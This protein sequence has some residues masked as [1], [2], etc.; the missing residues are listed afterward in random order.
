MGREIYPAMS[1]GTRA[2]R[3]LDVLSNNLANVGTTGFKADRATFALHS[4][5][6]A[7]DL[8]PDSA[9]ARLAAAWNALDGEATDFS[10][11]SLQPSSSPT[12]LALSGEGFFSVQGSD[13]VVRLTRDGS[14]GIG[15]DGYLA[16]RQGDRVLDQAGRPIRVEGGDFLVDRNGDVR[17]GGQVVTRIGTVD[18]E[19]RAALAKVAGNRW[20]TAAGQDLRPVATEVQQFQ[21][22]GSNVEAVNA[23]TQLVA[24]SRYYEAFSRS[25]EAS[26][27][28]D[29]QLNTTVGR[30]DR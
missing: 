18:V 7:R 1:G 11:G 4:P 28:M 21:L 12:H 6:A 29:E 16:T 20:E 15:A 27:E 30:I 17:L 13:G 9:E 23:L 24:I 2:L 19:D 22:E 3:M 10:Q 25:L 26:S 14:F 8:D 5:A